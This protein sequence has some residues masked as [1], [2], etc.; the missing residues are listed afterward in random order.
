MLQNLHSVKSTAVISNIC[1]QLET[2]TRPQS[3]VY[4][5]CHVFMLQFI[6]SDIPTYLQSAQE[7]AEWPETEVYLSHTQEQ[8]I[9]VI[10]KSPW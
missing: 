5:G 1:Q 6:S 7:I 10:I 2:N 4:P 3:Q 9:I 8:K